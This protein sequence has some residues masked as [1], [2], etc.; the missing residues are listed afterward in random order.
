[1]LELEDVVVRVVR[2][3]ISPA[4]I[5]ILRRAGMDESLLDAAGTLHTIEYPF[6]SVHELALSGRGCQTANGA[7]W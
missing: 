1:V 6:A 4:F 5:A 2:P 7:L 3:L